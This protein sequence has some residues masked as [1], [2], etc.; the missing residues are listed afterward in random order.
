MNQIGSPVFVCIRAEDVLLESAGSGMTSA[1][2]HLQGKVSEIIP[3]GVMV[4]VKVDCGFTVVAV[5]TKGAQEE[6]GLEQGSPVVAVI[7]AGA[8]HLVPRSI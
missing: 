2:N 7:K 8:V 5:V 6:L 3:H 1:R 4:H